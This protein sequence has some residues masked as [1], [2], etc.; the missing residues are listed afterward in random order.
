MCLLLYTKALMHANC[1]HDVKI[2][3]VSLTH[4][5]F[6]SPLRWLYSQTN[7]KIEEI[8]GLLRPRIVSLVS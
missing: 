8:I 1:T 3:Y 4:C 5:D 7:K 6:F 2:D